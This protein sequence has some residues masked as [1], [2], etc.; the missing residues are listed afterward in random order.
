MASKSIIYFLLTSI[1]FISCNR[2][3]VNVPLSAISGETEIYDNSPV[4]FFKKGDSININK[5]GLISSTNWFF[6]IEK[7]LPLR[8]I[9]PNL[10]KLRTKKK[11]SIHSKAG[12]HNYFVYSDTLAKKNSFFNFDAIDYNYTKHVKQSSALQHILY[13]NKRTVL[14]DEKPISLNELRKKIQET[15]RKNPKATISLYV[16]AESNFQEYLAAA[17]PFEKTA[18]AKDSMHYIIE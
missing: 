15:Y 12:T 14:L 1:F 4:W 5:G 16:T 8:L 3:S 10:Q 13:V 6:A 2:E 11:N 17:L 9:V 18:I 7:E